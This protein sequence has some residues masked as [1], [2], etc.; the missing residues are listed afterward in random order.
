MFGIVFG[1]C[2]AVSGLV[3]VGLFVLV[4]VGMNNMGSGK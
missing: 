2:L 4:A 3:I 1:S